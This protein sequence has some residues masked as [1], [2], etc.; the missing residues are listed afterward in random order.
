MR[1]HDVRFQSG[2]INF[3]DF[4]EIPVR[5]F[6]HFRVRDQHRL[7][8]FGQ[9][10]DVVAFRHPEIVHHLLIEGKHRR[11]RAEFGTH[12]G[13]RALAG[14]ADGSGARPEIFDDFVGAALDGESSADGE[15]HVLGGRPSIQPAGEL[16]SDELGVQHFP[17]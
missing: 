9:L 14:C 1:P 4:I 2:Q 12:V 16:D 6:I 15:D 5:R 10:G 17:R 8:G 7:I 13:Y 11:G 3:Q